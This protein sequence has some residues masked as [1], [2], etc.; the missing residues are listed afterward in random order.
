MRLMRCD[1]SVCS[2]RKV[3]LVRVWIV[4]WWSNIIRQMMTME[5]VDGQ[6][7]CC[8]LACCCVRSAHGEK[9][10]KFNRQTIEKKALKQ[11]SSTEKSTQL[12]LQSFWKKDFKSIENRKSFKLTCD[13]VSR[14][15][16][17]HCCLKLTLKMSELML[18]QYFN[19]HLHL[20]EIAWRHEKPKM[21]T[22]RDFISTDKLMRGDDPLRNWNWNPQKSS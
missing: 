20:P 7:K 6:L 12:S 13:F 3:N 8:A 16:W 14:F 4:C 11:K 10:W 5:I 22:Y 21:M 9:T 2:M 17:L 1:Y 15:D 19:E 18:I